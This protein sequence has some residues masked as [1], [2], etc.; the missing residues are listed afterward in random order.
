[1]EFKMKRALS[2]FLIFSLV[3]SSLLITSCKNKEEEKEVVTGVD[4]RTVFV[5]SSSSAE[6]YEP[7]FSIYIKSAI[8]A[9]DCIYLVV[10]KFSNDLSTHEVAL[11]KRSFDGEFVSEFELSSDVNVYSNCFVKN[12]AFYTL[13]WA[14]SLMKFDL[15]TGELTN[16]IL[17]NSGALGVNEC[18]DGYVVLFAGKIEKFNDNDEVIGTIENDSWEQYYGNTSYYADGDNEYVVSGLGLYPKYYEL[19][20]ENESSYMVFD[21]RNLN[22]EIYGASSNYY[23]DNTGEYLMDFKNSTMTPLAIWNEMNLQPCKYSDDEPVYIGIDNEHFM[24]VFNYQ[25]GIAQLVYY[26]YECDED[27]SMREPLVVGGF[28]CRNDLALNWAIYQFNTS[29]NEFRAYIED[30]SEEFGY[31][32]NSDAASSLA[33]LIQYF[34]SGNA[35]DVFYGNFFDY[36]GFADSGMILN[37][38]DYMDDDFENRFSGITESVRNLMMD[39]DGNCYRIFASYQIEGYFAPASI[40]GDRTDMSLEEVFSLS[41]ELGIM[42]FDRCVSSDIVHNS[43]FYSSHD[44]NFTSEELEEILEYAYE[45][46][47]VD[48]FAANPPTLSR[49]TVNDYLLWDKTIF[50]LNFLEDDY[51]ET[52]ETFTYIGYP[53]LEGSV[54]PI[55]PFGQMAIS[56]STEY[57]EECAKLLYYLLDDEVQF[58]SFNSSM[59]PVDNT[60]LDKYLTYAQDNRNI[61]E[62][63]YLYASSFEIYT[64]A[65]EASV[66][67]LRSTINH[68]DCLEYHDWG[69]SEIIIEEVNSYYTENKPVSVIALSLYSRINVYLSEE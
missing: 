38:S 29:Q 42:P 51:K 37:I 59:F 41:E 36:D 18:D 67:S 40:L 5:Y 61:P 30:Y 66:E 33:S 19:D 4:G 28:N 60:V 22:S 14:N 1:M 52:G 9:D 8:A 7:G 31:S 27:F 64:G 25:N 57:P 23:F 13:S 6:L 58:L 68:I 39:E 10:E 56:S 35:P 3:F 15:S 26:T 16:S 11:Q 53:S 45:Y 55:I 62:E 65:S 34:N 46:G 44:E 43:V 48:I 17:L 47:F 50:S 69:M 2:I 49:V 21:T 32:T 63:D 54:H 24:Q 20:F 12:G